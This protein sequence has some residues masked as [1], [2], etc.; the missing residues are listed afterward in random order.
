MN[1]ATL[2]PDVR[3]FL[4]GMA[5][6][7]RPPMNDQT[8]AM[9]RQIPAEMMEQMLQ[10]I[11]LPV[12]DLGEIRDVTMPGPGGDI[13]LRLFDVRKERAAGPVVVF[14]HGGGFVV[15]SIGTH[16]PMAAEIS[17][18]LDLP[19]VSVE[20]RLA[21]ENP[22]PAAPDDAEAAA[23]W[24]AENGSAF[25]REFTSL[26]PCG[27]SAGGTLTLVTTL[28]LRDKPAGLPLLMQIPIYPVS[29]RS[30]PYPSGI[31][32][33]NGFG[34]DQEGMDYYDAAYRSDKTHWR[35]SPLFADLAGLPPTLL[36]TA[37]FDPLRD[38]GRAFA[39]KATEAGVQVT[40][41]EFPG[42][43]HGFCTYRR[44]IPSAQ[45]DFATI[46]GL[47]RGLMAEALG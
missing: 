23:R 43:I 11:D 26:I 13:A 27:D 8:I 36:V 47:A 20:Y 2:R 38:E 33:A 41:R 24:V 9:M 46:M 16:A 7:P 4:D 15:G 18:Q 10:Q 6:N 17:R 1:D 39:A 14:Y 25:G 32:F 3:G 40:Y 45:Q 30:K 22:W 28:A 19:V 21:P 34:L 12:G 35:A 29:D 42:T 37:E 5:A 44:G 31:A